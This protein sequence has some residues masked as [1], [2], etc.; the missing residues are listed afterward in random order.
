M[1]RFAAAWQ[2]HQDP[3]VL[4]TTTGWNA[5]AA[6]VTQAHEQDLNAVQTQ[7]GGQLQQLQQEVH[8][9]RVQIEALRAVSTPVGGSMRGL[10]CKDLKPERFESNRKSPQL[11][12]QWADDMRAWLRRV[13]PDSAS[14]LAAVEELTEWNGLKL[15]SNLVQKGVTPEQQAA[16]EANLTDILRKFT[17]GEARDLVDTTSD[18]GEAWYRLK[19]RFHARTVIGA[20][21]I[22]NKL[23]EQKRPSSLAESFS[24]LTEIR[25]LVKEFQ[26]Q[27]PA[28]PMP[29]AMIKAAYMK[30]VPEN[31]KKGLEMQ[32]DVDRSEVHVIEDKVMQFIRTNSTGVASMDTSLLRQADGAGGADWGPRATGA[33]GMDGGNWEEHEGEQ[34]HHDGDCGHCDAEGYWG[35]ETNSFSKG[36]GKT[37]G[38]GTGKGEFRGSCYVCGQ[39]GHSQRFCP[40]KGKG[41]GSGK[42]KGY[43]FAKGGGQQGYSGKGMSYYGREGEGTTNKYY[44]REGEGTSNKYFAMPALSLFEKRPIRIDKQDVQRTADDQEEPWQVPVRFVRTISNRQ[45]THRYVPATSFVHRTIFDGLRE[46]DRDVVDAGDVH[47]KES[48]RKF[49]TQD[50]GAGVSADRRDSKQSRNQRK[51]ASVTLGLFERGN[52]ELCEM[53]HSQWAPLPQPLVVDSG[54][55]ETVIP[56]EWLP[57]HPTRESAGSRSN[58]YYTTADGNKV[59]NEGQKQVIISTLNGGQERQ[60]TFQV[61]QVHKALGSVSQ[62]VRNGNRVVFDT[63]Y[64]G[65]DIS[66]I[67]NKAT[68]E[69]IPMRVENGVY[70]IDLVVAPPS[71][72]ADCEHRE[73]CSAGFARQG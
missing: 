68:K 59:Y 60:M 28:E 3:Q 71:Y 14:V 38:K 35:G 31:Y 27:S 7:L 10:S 19:D 2:L 18:S 4:G 63:D 42:S 70:V 50:G 13:D 24:L 72:C 8:S 5:F 62:M 47:S 34:Y 61:A 67:E 12:K 73:D 25:G 48:Q 37:K 16:A 45:A 33:Y 21:S 22:A 43:S 29:T 64:T 57:A 54:A 69:R 32:I 23:Q 39:Y 46:E 52:V 40:A 9:Q 66:H 36:K 58:E 11:F 41:K 26:R 55:G 15:A 6:S 20:T 30:V 17:Q 65:R 53:S 44:G 49:Q 1:A 56:S 51:R